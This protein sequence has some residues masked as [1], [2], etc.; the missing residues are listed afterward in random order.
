MAGVWYRAGTLSVTLNSKKVVGSG[1][2]WASAL[3]GIAAGKMLVIP[4][5]ASVDIYEID[6]VESNTVLYLVDNY[7]G[8]TGANKAYAIDNTRTASFPDFAR[9]MV[10]M[11]NYYQANLSAF[12]QFYTSTSGTVTVTAPDGSEHVLIP[13]KKIMGDSDT[14]LQQTTEQANQAKQAASQAAN[15]VALARLPEPDVKIT[16]NDGLRIERGYGTHD[17][18]DVSAAQD[19]SKLVQLPTRSVDFSRASGATGIN[20]SGELVT[21]ENDQPV[22]GPDGLSVFGS[23]TNLALWSENFGESVWG[24]RYGSTININTA[25]ITDPYGTNLA[26]KHVNTDTN[27]AGSYIALPNSFAKDNT[28][29]C[30]S[31]FVKRGSQQTAAITIYSKLSTNDR[32]VLNLDYDTGVVS[33]NSVGSV[34]DAIGGVVTYAN[35]WYR[36]WLSANMLAGGSGAGVRFAPSIWSVPAEVGSEYGYIFGAQLEE[37]RYPSPYIKTEGSAVTRSP[38]I[39]SIPAKNNLPAPGQPFTIVVD[40]AIPFLGTRNFLFVV[41]GSDIS[42]I[43]IRREPGGDLRANIGTGTG[44]NYFLMGQ[45]SADRHRYVLRYNG[46][47]VDS[48]VDG[49]GKVTRPPLPVSYNTDSDIFLGSRIGGD[50]LCESI[51]M[52]LIYH[53]ALTD[54]QITALGGPQ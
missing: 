36:V 9:R 12:Q 2:Q 30:A 51:S 42:G 33:V 54:E 24:P 8:A 31:V 43:Y 15:A 38:D 49:G 17:T 13:W 29:Y 6:F 53:T 47:N 50:Y 39:V 18:I 40:A 28:V 35:G 21:L 26:N 34:T 37:G 20:K 32:A 48:F 41:T 11:L 14:L 46:V 4:S 5:G 52:F 19:G 45:Q 10:A 27:T 23:T 1:T 3:N 44:T 7:R 22:I 16:F 25:E